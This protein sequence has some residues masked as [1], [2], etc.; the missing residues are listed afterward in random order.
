MLRINYPYH[1]YGNIVI[2]LMLLF[3]QLAFYYVKSGT[4]LN[5]VMKTIAWLW[6]VFGIIYIIYTLIY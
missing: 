5:I 6:T 2:S 1:R 4:M 3:Q